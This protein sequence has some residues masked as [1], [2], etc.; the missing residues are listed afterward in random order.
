MAR[1]PV[2]ATTRAPA[3][4]AV[5][6]SESHVLSITNYPLWRN[7]PD[8]GADRRQFGDLMSDR[9]G[10]IP[11]EGVAAPSAFGRLAVDDLAD[12]LGRDQGASM[13]SMSGL[14]APLL[15]RGRGRWP[16]LA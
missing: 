11:G 7:R 3:F 14:P 15:A 5:G 12:L 8:H 2:G 10:V 1:R 13:T 16:S 6:L 4:E 9:F